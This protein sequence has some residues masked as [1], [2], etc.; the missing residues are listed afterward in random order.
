MCLSRF[1]LVFSNFMLFR[2]SIVWD[3][4]SLINSRWLVGS[5]LHFVFSFT[6]AGVVAVVG[7][8]FCCFASCGN[9]FH[10]LEY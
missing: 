4:N 7:L 5:V 8:A 3:V 10:I 6:S 1:W 2:C 9:C